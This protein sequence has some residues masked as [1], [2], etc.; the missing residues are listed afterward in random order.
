MEMGPHKNVIKIQNI[1]KAAN[2]LDMYIAFELMESDLHTVIRAEICRDIQVRFIA[3]QLLKALKFIHT[4]NICHRDLK[5]SNILI[6][7][8]C[9]VKLADFGLA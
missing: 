3:W 9:M 2:G 8:N 1:K 7:K 4:A 6:D 5:P